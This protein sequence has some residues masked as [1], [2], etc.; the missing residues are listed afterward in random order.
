MRSFHS[1]AVIAALT[2]SALADVEFLTPKAGASIP[3]G[4]LSVTWQDSGDSPSIDA[5]STYTLQVILGGNGEQ[6]WQ[7]LATATGNFAT[8]NEVTVTGITP[9]LAASTK[10]GL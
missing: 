6:D 2:T 4:P 7:G 8:G 5:L 9:A 3:A 10:N 1:C